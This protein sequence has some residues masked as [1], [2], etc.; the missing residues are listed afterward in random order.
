MTLI[1]MEESI[2]KKSSID[3]R[4]VIDP[5]N[6]EKYFAKINNFKGQNGRPESSKEVAVVKMDAR[7]LVDMFLD[8][9]RLMPFYF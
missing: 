3:G 9:V 5:A 6:Y 7:I 4:L 2:W 1:Q 8:T